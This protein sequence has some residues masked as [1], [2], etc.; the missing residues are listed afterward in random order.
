MLSKWASL[1]HTSPWSIGEIRKIRMIDSQILNIQ[2]ET[3]C[4]IAAL[5]GTDTRFIRTKLENVT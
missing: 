3:I 5:N 1:I 4:V 2:S